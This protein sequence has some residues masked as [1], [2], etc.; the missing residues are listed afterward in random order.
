MRLRKLND[1]GLTRFEAWLAEGAPGEV[2]IDLVRGQTTSSA[3]QQEITVSQKVFQDRYE[4]GKYLVETL[5]PLDAVSLSN[6]R[7]LWATLALIW[8]D[9]LCPPFS[10]G[11]RRLEKSYRYIPSSDYRS[12]Y[13]HLV[14]S[15]WKLVADHGEN[16]RLFLLPTVDG[17]S[18]LRRHGEILEQLGGRQSVLRSQA[19]I[20]EAN[21]LYASPVTGRPRKGVAGRGAGT[22]N[23]LGLVLRQLALTFDVEALEDGNLLKILPV[24]FDRWKDVPTTA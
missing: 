13:R 1:E 24:E 6:D 9:Q 19:V 11:G 10:V 7:L 15:P 8:F 4:F 14:R 18:P 16:A 5:A 21:R 22:V 2:P 17:P 3:L 20:S 12:Y 23:R